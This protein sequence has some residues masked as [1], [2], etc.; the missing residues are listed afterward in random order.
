M[1][2]RRVVLA[3][4][5]KYSIYLLWGDVVWDADE[6]HPRLLFVRESHSMGKGVPL[7]FYGAK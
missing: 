3:L 1:R 2:E 5:N 6:E 4:H 7:D